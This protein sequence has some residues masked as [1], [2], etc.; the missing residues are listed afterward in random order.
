MTVLEVNTPPNLQPRAVEKAPRIEW[1]DAAKGIGII[2]VVVGHAIVGLRDG[3]LIS[4]DSVLA[5]VLKLI[6]SFHMPL[7]FFLSGIF[8]AKRVASGAWAFSKS[9]TIKLGK[10]YLIWLP[11]Q[12][13]MLSLAG[14]LANKPFNGQVFDYVSILWEPKY[15]FWFIYAL[16]LMNIM[17]A[18]VMPRLG[19]G[20]MIAS[21]LLLYSLAQWMKLPPMFWGICWFA[22]YYGLGIIFGLHPV[23]LNINRLTLI[24]AAILLTAIWLY[25]AYEIRQ[26][27]IAL[28]ALSTFGT[29]ITGSMAT[30]LWI[31]GSG[32]AISNLFAYLGREALPIYLIHVMFVAGTRIALHK[33]LHVDNVYAILFFAS[34]MGIAGPLVIKKIADRLKISSQIGLA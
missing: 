16:L 31:G 8:I 28:W 6:Y 14:S 10:A 9:S 19:A 29:A 1:V 17:S 20:I 33:I 21:C 12:M 2:L 27:G 30:V 32:K 22:P 3:A 13:L 34:V 11:V 15:N 5:I 4:P 7:F 26:R 24:L 23:K 25:L 18:L